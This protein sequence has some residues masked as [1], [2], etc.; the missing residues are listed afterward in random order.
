MLWE[1]AKVEIA[2]SDADWGKITDILLGARGADKK[3]SGL[4]AFN[5]AVNVYINYPFSAWA[6]QAGKLVD[7]IAD[8]VKKARGKDLKAAMKVSPKQMVAVS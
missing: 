4:G 7:E 8:V 5:H 1:A 6:M 3:R 2:K